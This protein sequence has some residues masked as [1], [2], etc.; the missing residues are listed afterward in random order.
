VVCPFFWWYTLG[1]TSGIDAGFILAFIKMQLERKNIFS[2]DIGWLKSGLKY[3]LQKDGESYFLMCKYFFWFC[4]MRCGSLNPILKIEG[5][6]GWT[7]VKTIG[8]EFIHECMDR[9]FAEENIIIYG[10]VW[11]M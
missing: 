10:L 4:M 1:S 6:R 3:W 2:L 5:G 9:M 11:N 8:V 7:V